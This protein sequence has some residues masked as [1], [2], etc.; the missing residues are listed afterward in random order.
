[1]ARGHVAEMRGRHVLAADR[2]EIEDVDRLLGRLDEGVGAHGRP[3]QRIGKLAAGRK[4]F[5]GKGVQCAR[6]PQR[7][8]GQELQALAP[9][10]GVIG[11]YRRG[12][13]SPN[14]DRPRLPN[15]F[16]WHVRGARSILHSAEVS[17]QS[18]SP[19]PPS[20]RGS[21]MPTPAEKRTTFRKLHAQGCFVIP[22]P[23]D[24]GSARYLQGL[25]FKA[26]AS[27]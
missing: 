15:S 8:C 12:E 22:N 11:K 24:V 1:D 27:T 3:H 18:P 19:T 16:G 17:R 2:L 7:T 4:P 20:Q 13:P 21:P 10:G 5:A 26:L 14:S 6:T 25:G 9:A 23:W